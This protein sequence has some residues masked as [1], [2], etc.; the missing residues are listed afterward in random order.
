MDTL[1]S[2]FSTS[3]A[4]FSACGTYRYTLTREWEEDP[5]VVFLLFNP[6][7]ATATEEDPTIRRCIGFARRWGYGRLTIL[8]LYAIRGT[9]PRTPSQTLDPVGPLND[10]WIEEVCGDAREVICAWGCAQHMKSIGTRIS[11][12]LEIFKYRSPRISCLGYRKDG[13][14]RHPLMLHYDTPREPFVW[15]GQ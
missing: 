10:Y 13:H 15:R 5:R 8:N 1:F 2:K 7:T 9:N 11:E 3:S 4:Q 14:P 12:V 6:S